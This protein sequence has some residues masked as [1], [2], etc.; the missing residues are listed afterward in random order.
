MADISAFPSKATI[1]SGDLSLIKQMGAQDKFTLAADVSAGQVVVYGSVS[2]EVTP[3]TGATTEIVAGVVMDDGS[4]GDLVTVFMIG[5]IA[6]LTNFST[7]VAIGAGKWVQ[8]NDNA[9][10]GTINE[11][12]APSGTAYN[13]YNIVGIALETIAA[14]S[15]G[16]CLIFPQKMYLETS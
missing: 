10:K 6:R 13:Y 8:T 12:A 15:Y 7:T 2:G 1:E 4:D 16:Y 9:V 3:A 11:V 14:S 5:S